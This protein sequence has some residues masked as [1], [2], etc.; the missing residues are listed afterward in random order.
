MANETQTRVPQKPP[1]APSPSQVPN[2]G[3]LELVVYRNNFYRDNYRRLMVVCLALLVLIGCVVYW[4]FYERT[5]KPAP[6][7]FATTY[8]GKLIALIPLNQPNMEDNALLQWATEAAVASYTFN[9]VNYRKALQDIRIYFTQNGYQYYIKALTESNNLDAIINKKFVASAAPTGAPVILEKRIFKE[10][11]APGGVYG[12]T[13]QLPMVI[14]YQSSTEQL[15]QN[16]ILDMLILRTSTL[17]S[18]KG[19]GIASFVVQ[20][21]S[22]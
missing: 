2:T 14:N 18:P 20:E 13:V 1:A 19:V 7:Y 15:S 9:F 11:E 6:E 8:D 5:H 17:E 22:T 3:A 4:A 16:I 21:G 12:W 10:G